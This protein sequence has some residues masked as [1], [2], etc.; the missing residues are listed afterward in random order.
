MPSDVTDKQR[1]A[2]HLWA[3]QC[4]RQTTATFIAVVMVLFLMYK[5]P[6]PYHTSILSWQGWV[7]K[8]LDGHPE[9]ICCELGTT[10]DILSELVSVLCSLGHDD[11][12]Y[13][14][15]EEQLVIFLYMSITRLTI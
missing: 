13:I 9:C 14:Q 6:E 4:I 2:A 7:N 10:Q 8:L 1:H 15:L 3:V 11:L 5:T 12:K